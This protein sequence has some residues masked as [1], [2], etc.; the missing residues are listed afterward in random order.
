MIMIWMLEEIG[1]LSSFLCFYNKCLVAI[2]WPTDDE[3]QQFGRMF[4]YIH[5]HIYIYIF[6]YI[7][8]YIYKHIPAIFYVLFTCFLKIVICSFILLQ[9]FLHYLDNHLY[10]K[11]LQ[12]KELYWI[13]LGY[14]FWGSLLW[15]SFIYC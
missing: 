4:I 13:I 5:T 10:K 12:L 3:S 11:A 8:I 9:M 7:Y 14:V 1:L 15:N 6:I 2:F